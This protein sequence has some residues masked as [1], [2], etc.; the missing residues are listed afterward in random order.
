MATVGSAC[1]KVILCG[2]HAVVYG[3]PAIALPLPR[4]RT[5]ATATAREP[6]DDSR[7]DDVEVI[8]PDINARYWMLLQPG[9]PLA[10]IIQLTLTRIG[11]SPEHGDWRP[12]RLCLTSDI[13]VGANLGS[14]AAAS[15]AAARATAEFF[16]QTLSPA[17]LSAL[18]F[19]VELMHHG[20]PSGIDNTVVAFERPVWFI[21]GQPPQIL[22][23]TEALT[24]VIGDTG[25]ATP[26]RVPV[27]DVRAA[28]QRDPEACEA[29]FDRIAGLVIRARD[30]L[31]GHDL[32]RLGEAMNANHALLQTLTVSNA[33]LDAL[34]IAARGAGAL[35]AK[36]SGGGRGGNM[37]A[38]ARDPAHAAAVADALLAAGATRVLGS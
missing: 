26:T 16:G 15:V 25:E 20:T 8:A 7:A 37:I 22:A 11:M 29:L 35:G 28:W 13:P 34:C 24:L 27:G 10:R 19:E 31:L 38:L 21:R 6:G 2:E 32:D 30:A 33:D 3:R 18:A 12:F 17:E 1:A 5:T 36:L 23:D 14:G 9:R 4:L